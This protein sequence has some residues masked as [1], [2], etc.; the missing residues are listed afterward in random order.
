MLPMTFKP[1]DTSSPA[2]AGGG[3]D[4]CFRREE[5]YAMRAVAASKEI[6][7][8]ASAPVRQCA[9]APVRQ[10]A[11]APVRQLTAFLGKSWLIEEQ[12]Q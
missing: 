7:E 12:I 6:I 10:C 8:C 2:S 1:V 4:A 11:S 5:R 3:S 9:S